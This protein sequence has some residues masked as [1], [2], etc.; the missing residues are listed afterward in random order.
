LPYANVDR[1]VHIAASAPGSGMS[2]EFGVSAEFYVQYRERS[3][4]LE[5]VSTY[6]SFTNTLRVGDRVERVRMSWP[7]NS[8]FSTLGARPILGRVPVREDEDRVAVISD[9]LW[10]SWFSRDPSVVGKTYQIGGE[11]R[12]IVGVMGPEFKF[13]ND[14]TLLWISS[15]IRPEGITPGRFGTHLIARM[16]PG[17]TPEAV[18]RELT[19]L[20]K[21]LPE[22]FGGSASY[23][24]L[25][26]QHHAVVRT[27]EDQLFG[28]VAGSLWVLLGA[29]GIVLLIACANVANLFMVRAEGRQRDLAV[30]RAIGAARGALIRS[31]MAE[32]VVVAAFAGVVAAGLAWAGLPVLLRAAPQNIPRLDEVHLGLT[33]GSF[34][35]SRAVSF[36][37]FAHR[38]R[39]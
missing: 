17:A 38:H 4:L 37:P 10:T 1:L 12:T 27:L 23:A 19:A 36:Q 7:T 24:R 8:L 6:N 11:S 34:R 20:S 5:D 18:A 39:T 28:A 29:V 30:R 25:I 9:A 3:T 15:E 32:S 33:S 2:D 13:P 21:Q 14:G 26:A 35:R 31:Q 22:R 16:K